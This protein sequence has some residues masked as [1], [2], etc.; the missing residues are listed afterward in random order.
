MYLPFKLTK[1]AFS[2]QLRIQFNCTWQIITLQRRFLQ[3]TSY[4]RNKKYSNEI[5]NSLYWKHMFWQNNTENKW[6]NAK[7]GYEH[8]RCIIRWIV[9]GIIDTVIGLIGFIFIDIFGG[10]RRPL[11]QEGTVLAQVLGDV[12]NQFVQGERDEKC[13][14]HAASVPSDVCEAVLVPRQVTEK[15]IIR[16]SV[17]L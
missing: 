15:I 6:N 11:T 1:T 10:Q 5:N 7:H 17:T 16:I 2:P 9:N 8:M 3:N 14:I 4:L 12:S 13:G